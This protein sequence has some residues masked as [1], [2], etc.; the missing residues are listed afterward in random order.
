M[1]SSTSSL[2]TASNFSDMDSISEQSFGDFNRTGHENADVQD[3]FKNQ[4]VEARKFQRELLRSQKN[5]KKWTKTQVD[6]VAAIKEAEIEAKRYELDRL[7][8]EYEA[9]LAN[10]EAE[11]DAEMRDIQTECGELR[12]EIQSLEFELSEVKEQRKRNILQVRSEIAASIKNMEAREIDHDTQ[13]N[14]LKAVLD[15]LIAKHQNDLVAVTEGY[16][17]DEQIIATEIQRVSDSIE[18]HRKEIFKCDDTQGRRMSEAAST[19]EML[20]SE[21]AASHDR[22]IAMR[23]EVESTQKKLMQLQQELYKA[24][25]QSRILKEQIAY[26]EE[27]KKIMKNELNKLD[28][29]LWNSRKTV[30]L[31]NE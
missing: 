23:D 1:S 20:K 15:D 11:V 22:T 25:E 9:D 27:Q 13:I 6:T 12:N 7:Q 31:H 26:T 28:R 16:Q 19:I 14:Q 18:R 21:I 8:A 3:I 24:E 2:D 17:S 30:L 10:K 29:S 4:N 5:T